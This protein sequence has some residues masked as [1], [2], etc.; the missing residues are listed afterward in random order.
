M[1]VNFNVPILD[2]LEEAEL[3]A[4]QIGYEAAVE[5]APTLSVADIVCELELS[6]FECLAVG[7]L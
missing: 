3:L 6:L 2:P 1:T 7:V 5:Q 4:F